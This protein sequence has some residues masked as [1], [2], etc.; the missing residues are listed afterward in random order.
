[1]YKNKNITV[2]LPCFNESDALRNVIHDIPKIVDSIILIDNNSTD[3]SAQIAYENKLVVV[4][5]YKKGYGYACIKGIES[6]PSDSDIF[7][8]LDCDNSYPANAIEELLDI[9]LFNNL[10]FLNCS[11][12]PLADKGSM[13]YL[14]Y[15]GNLLLTNIINMLFKIRLSD[16]QSGMMIG[17]SKYIKKHKFKCK[18]MD[19]STELKMY[20]VMNK[21]YKY[22]ETNKK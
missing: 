7:I 16:T 9:F 11:R 18:G 1:M 21:I 2:I 22:G 8:L 15:F 4:D 10:D 19:F 6:I 14:N 20:F 17:T 5:E 13:Q 3:N 12:F